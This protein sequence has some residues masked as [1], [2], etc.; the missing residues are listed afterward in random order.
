[1]G[2]IKMTRERTIDAVAKM[3]QLTQAGKLVWKEANNINL[4]QFPDLKDLA[5]FTL[6]NVFRAPY[7]DTKLRLYK[8]KYT[9]VYTRRLSSHF[10]PLASALK[11]LRGLHNDEDTEE[12]KKWHTEVALEIVG[13]N[14]TG[15]WSFPDVNILDDLFLVVQQQVAGVKR[16]FE[17]LLKES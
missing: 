5:D 9:Q 13:Q 14:N 12:V 4:D 2:E 17:E 3:I 1:V 7:H 6:L 11:N 8:Y 10:D 16:L 15:L